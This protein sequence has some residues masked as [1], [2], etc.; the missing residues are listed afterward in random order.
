[1][2]MLDQVAV[3]IVRIVTRI[4]KQLLQDRVNVQIANLAKNLILAVLNVLNVTLVKP[5]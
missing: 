5:A 4:P 1:M 3:M 2:A